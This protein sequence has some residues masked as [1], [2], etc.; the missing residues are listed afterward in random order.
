VG[1]CRVTEPVFLVSMMVPEGRQGKG[2]RHRRHQGPIDSGGHGPDLHNNSI[3]V[4]LKP[5]VKNSLDEAPEKEEV[6]LP[7]LVIE[8]ALERL[9][10]AFDGSSFSITDVRRVAKAA[11]LDTRGKQ[12]KALRLAHTTSFDGM[13]RTTLSDLALTAVQ[14]FELGKEIWRQLPPSRLRRVL[15]AQCQEGV[16]WAVDLRER[17][18]EQAAAAA[19]R[20]TY[21]F[22]R[23]TSK[24][25]VE[26]VADG[27]KVIGIAADKQDRWREY[28]RVQEEQPSWP[29][30]G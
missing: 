27:T 3:S 12:W 15:A 26:G 30:I 13:K 6:H 10:D 2:V 17:V 22:E 23:R 9:T 18:D 19:L 25:I 11:D 5:Q 1:A 16:W 20:R 24:K 21:N 14:F 8:L 29:R 4:M 28:F 7:D